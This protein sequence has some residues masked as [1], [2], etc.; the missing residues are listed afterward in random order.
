MG[1]ITIDM[2][3]NAPVATV[4]AYVDDY[5][6]T[7]KYMKDLVK[8]QPTGK[9][10]HGKG[11]QFDVGMKAGPTTL[12]SVV[13]IT[14]WTENKAIGWHSNEGFKQIGMWAF[15]PK[16]EKT[17]VTFDMEYEFG[18]GIAG[19]L[20]GRAAEPIVR[21]NLQRSVETLKL[22]TEK[23]AQRTQAGRKAGAL[24]GHNKTCNKE[25]CSRL[26]ESSTK[27]ATKPAAR[28]EIR[29]EEL[30]EKA[31]RMS[32]VPGTASRARSESM[33]SDKTAAN[34]HEPHTGGVRVKRGLAEMLKGGVIM[35]VVTPEQA[36]IAEDAGAVAVMALERVPSDIRRDGGVARMSDVEPHQGD[37]RGGDDPGHGQGA[38]RSFR[39]GAGAA[40]AGCRLHRRVRGADS[41]GRGAPHRQV[42]VQCARS[43]AVR[44][45]SAR[46]CGASAKARR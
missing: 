19:K 1:R 2:T 44:A 30:V 21:G 18:G 31:L 25:R 14:T 27:P 34:G 3:I 13:D 41:R 36:K 38:H 4:F 32:C 12:T 46:R 24:Q 16:G 35:D 6:N 39:R 15:T 7:T 9:V 5:R 8:W 26:R 11:A 42:A 43:S 23:L 29:S 33:T 10:T 17:Q 28:A 37:H 45:T 40:G 20:L 22:H